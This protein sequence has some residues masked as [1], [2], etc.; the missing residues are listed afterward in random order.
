MAEFVT[1]EGL[2]VF[3]QALKALPQ[4]VGRNVLRGATSAA[5]RI[6]RDEAKGKA[7]VYT[8]PVSAGHPPPGTLRRSVIQKQIRELSGMTKQ[9]FYVTVR[10]G[11]KYAKQG[12]K[13][14]LS[15]DA[16]YASWVEFGTSN[17]AAKPFM[18]PAFESKKQ[19][20]INA[21]AEYIA[22]R[23]PDEARKLGFG[24]VGQ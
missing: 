7:P 15:Q 2:S 8:G 10:R 3:A 24:W 23:F 5:A 11:K 20:A 13:G 18:R 21:M 14:M 1:V 17:M 22:K 6:V 16:F 4:N 12:K 9:T 19:E